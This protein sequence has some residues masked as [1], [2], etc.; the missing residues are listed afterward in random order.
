MRPYG[1]SVDW[2]VSTP[3][4]SPSV[5]PRQQESPHLPTSTVIPC[6]RLRFHRFQDPPS[7]EDPRLDTASLPIHVRTGLPLDLDAASPTIPPR[8]G[9]KVRYLVDSAKAETLSTFGHEQEALAH[10]WPDQDGKNLP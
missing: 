10:I 9:D 8:G 1:C 7:A 2:Q 3:W 5:D 6:C 4:L